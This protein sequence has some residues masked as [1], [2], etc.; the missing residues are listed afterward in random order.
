VEQS[1]AGLFGYSYGGLFATYVALRRSPLFRRIGAGSQGI[2]PKVSTIFSMYEQE[3]QA[4][5]DHG[6]RMLHVSVCGPE[7]TAPSVYQ[8]LVG[9]GSAELMTLAGLRPLKGLA[10]SSR[11]IDGESHASGFVPSWFSYLRACYGAG[12]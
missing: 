2:L 3:L 9:A 10:F 7:I 12:R 11:I 5:A 1:E 6:G 4:S 8:S